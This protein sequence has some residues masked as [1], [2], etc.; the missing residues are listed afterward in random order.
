M[1]VDEAIQLVKMCISEVR[2]RVLVQQFK[3]TVKIVDKDGI[4]VLDVE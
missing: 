2:K 1:D 4:R 3:Y